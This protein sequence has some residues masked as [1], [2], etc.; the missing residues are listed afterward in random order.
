M[1]NDYDCSEAYCRSKATECSRGPEK[2]SPE[3][4]CFIRI[5]IN[6]PVY[7]TTFMIVLYQRLLSPF[8]GQCCRFSPTC[9][10]YAISA[11]KKHGFVKG[12]ILTCYRIIRCNPFCKGGIDPVTDS[13]KWICKKR[14][15]I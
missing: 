5:I 9:S 3:S 15:K 2:A 8:L 11:L 4:K 14:G 6:I 7:I 12:C 10:S 13:G 1:S